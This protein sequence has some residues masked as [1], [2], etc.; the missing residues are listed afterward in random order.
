MLGV[1]QVHF[2]VSER[3]SNIYREK[4]KKKKHCTKIFIAALF[5][6]VKKLTTE[7]SQE[8]NGYKNSM[9]YILQ[10]TRKLLHAWSRFE[11][12]GKKMIEPLSQGQNGIMRGEQP[13]L[14][15]IQLDVSVDEVM[16]HLG[17]GSESS[18]RAGVGGQVKQDQQ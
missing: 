11:S 1:Q 2:Q 13:C 15:E 5:V 17:S 10:N 8:G 18:S 14:M 6:T 9:L 3:D 4:E 7:I 16:G 12:T